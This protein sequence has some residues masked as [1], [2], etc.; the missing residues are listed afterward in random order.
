MID[1]K[2]KP[3]IGHK[4]RRLRNQLGITQSDMA[5]AIG[6][7]ASYLNLIEHNQ[8]PVTVALLFKLGQSFDIDLKDFATD[9]TTRLLTDVTEFFADPSIAG[10]SV[11]KREMRDF[12]NSQ[13]NIASAMLQMYTTFHFWK[14]RSFLK[15]V[16]KR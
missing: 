4:I 3:M 12:V 15:S 5:Q 16:I 1:I 7:S 11:S 8:R 2:E 9:D 6:I 10:H 14:N 13:P